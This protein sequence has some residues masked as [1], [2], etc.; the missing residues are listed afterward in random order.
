MPVNK[1][2]EAI[3]RH[4]QAV[5]ISPEERHKAN[6]K[7]AALKKDC[8]V[9]TT[10]IERHDEPAHKVNLMRTQRRQ[11]LAQIKALQEGLEW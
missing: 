2:Q 6:E 11:K 4:N 3:H 8:A 5:H 10:M 9:L 1:F 7:L